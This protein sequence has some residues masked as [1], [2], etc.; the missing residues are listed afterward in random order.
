MSMRLS[1]SLDSSS[2]SHSC[3]I[4]CLKNLISD[5]Y[6]ALSSGEKEI[7]IQGNSLLKPLELLGSDPR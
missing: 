4:I 6:L 3:Y 2:F 5:S 1:S 7:S